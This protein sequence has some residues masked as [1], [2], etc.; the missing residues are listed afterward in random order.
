M[1]TDAKT[2]L[3]TAAAAAAVA[4][5]APLVYR[6]FMIGRGPHGLQP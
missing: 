5:L 4:A 2:L 3:L 1:H 6:A